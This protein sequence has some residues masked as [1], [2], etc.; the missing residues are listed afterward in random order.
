MTTLRQF[1]RA[2]PGLSPDSVGH[3][4]TLAIMV[5][6]SSL[7]GW[8]VAGQVLAAL[9]TIPAATRR[10]SDTNLHERLAIGGPRDELRQLAGDRRPARAL[11]GGVRRPAPV[12]G[13]RLARLAHAADDDA[14]WSRSRYLR[15]ASQSGGPKQTG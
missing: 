6:L 8:V 3:P 1:S 5:V 13:Q 9:R 11:G 7:L 4:A 2:F 12:R 15:C 10:I 14:R